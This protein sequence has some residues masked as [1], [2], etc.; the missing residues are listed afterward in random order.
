M[1]LIFN[2][3]FINKNSFR[4]SPDGVLAVVPGDLGGGEALCHTAH[5]PV[6]WTLVIFDLRFTCKM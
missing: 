6:H 5:L 3:A 1:F 2:R 4:A